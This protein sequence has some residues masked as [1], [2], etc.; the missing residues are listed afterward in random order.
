MGRLNPLSLQM[1]ITRMF[2]QGQSF[3]ATTKVQEWLKERGHNPMDYDIIFHQ[4]PAP[5]GSKEVM[6]VQIELRRKDGQ[7]VDSWLQEQANLQA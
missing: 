4:K 5:P 7:P 2:E 6:V 3:F 1:Q